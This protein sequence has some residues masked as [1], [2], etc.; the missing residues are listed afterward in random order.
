MANQTPQQELD[1]LCKEAEQLVESL[2]ELLAACETAK[3]CV[4][5]AEA[6]ADAA[7]DLV[8]LRVSDLKNAISQVNSAFDEVARDRDFVHEMSLATECSNC[9][10][11]IDPVT[12]DCTVYQPTG[13]EY[14]FRQ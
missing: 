6:K 13:V 10:A 9:G 8:R 5:L 7:L 3:I 14:I 1:A 11:D 2:S 12:G 4:Q